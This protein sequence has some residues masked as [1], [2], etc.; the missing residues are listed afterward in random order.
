[1]KSKLM[2]KNLIVILAGGL[3]LIFGFLFYQ[4]IKAY[5]DTTTHP[6]L[7]REIIDFYEL[8]GGRKFTEEQKQCVIQGSIDEDA[9]PRWLNHFYDPVFER[10]LDTPMPFVN[11]YSSKNWG[12]Y[13]KYQLAR[14]GQT[15]TA[16]VMIAGK[17]DPSSMP[18]VFSYE[19]GIERYARNKEKD[20]YLTLGHILHLIE[21]LTVPE[22]TRN[23]P[24]PGGKDSSFYENWTKNNSSG[25]TQDLGKR[26]YNQGRKPIIYSDL[27]SYFDNLPVYTN[28]YFFSQRTI[29]SDI[30]QKPKIVF[31]DGTFAYGLD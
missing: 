23:D 21:D 18:F 12:L 14:L 31:E 3:F 7:T 25:L 30:Y 16:G 28:N 29:K 26:I 17:S 15:G 2:N 9:A 19:A 10:G 20:A 5:S 27:G 13:S 4:N 6:D 8:S 11:G 22:H 24:H 1:M